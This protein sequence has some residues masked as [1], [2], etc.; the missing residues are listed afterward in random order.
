M[1]KLLIIN[2]STFGHLTDSYMWCKYLKDKF[3]ITFIGFDALHTRVGMDGVNIKYIS[4]RGS[5]AIREYRFLLKSLWH[6]LLFKGPILIVYFDKA[7][8]LKKLVFWKKIFLDIRTFG[9]NRDPERRKI[10]DRSLLSTIHGFDRVTIISEGLQEKLN[11][12][13]VKSMILPLGAEEISLVDTNFDELRLLYVG[14][15][16]GRSLEKTIIGVKDFKKKYPNNKI[17]YEIIGDGHY[18]ELEELKQLTHELALDDCITFHGRL[19]HT[20]LEH[21][22]DKCNIGI[23]FVPKT[24]YYEFQPPTKTFEYILS[25][26]YTIA[27]S[28]H[29]NTE[30]INSDNGILINDTSEEFTAALENIWQNRASIDHDKIR[31]SLKSYKWDHI[32][33]DILYP[34]LSKY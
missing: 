4:C 31:A 25:G 2:K 21:F 18:G 14:I 28:T 19:P 8:W 33:N 10:F 24:D 29:A 1:R 7:I 26:L 23:S 22:F 17:T 5:R 20:Q 15:L 30:L 3:D 16:S 12:I 32:V 13:G 34:I 9:V 27:T 11:H 6:C